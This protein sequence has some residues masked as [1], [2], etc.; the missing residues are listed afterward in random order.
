M[1]FDFDNTLDHRYN[2]S[3][4]WEQQ[5]YRDDI[6]G[7]GTADLD[8]ACAPCIKVAL[9]K[10]ASEN[11]YNYRK[12]SDDYFDTVINWYFRKYEL[13]IQKEWLS[14]VPSTIGSIR[15][16]LALWGNGKKV[17][18]Q[19]PYFGPLRN[20]IES[21]G[22][23][24]IDNPMVINDGHF[25]I[26]FED[27]ERKIVKEKPAVFL[28]VNPH[29]P[30]G[31]VFTREELSRLVEICFAH[32]VLILSDEVHS[33][34]CY[35]DNKHI[36]ILK[37]SEKAKHISVQVMSM[38][39]GFNM[40]SLPHAI[41][42]IA[43]ASLREEWL[44]EIIP[45]SFGYA[46][47]SF[48]IAAV[49]AVMKEGD[50]WLSAVTAYLDENRKKVLEFLAEFYPDVKVYSPEGGYLIWIDIKSQNIGEKPAVFFVEKFGISLNDGAEFGQE[51]K[52]YIRINFGLPKAKLL[53]AL[54]RIKS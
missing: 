21:A 50:E 36:P 45:Y 53:E 5:K 1:V 38:S 54:N 43:D 12:K 13:E 7:M 28:L 19:S 23:E 9:E 29:N 16:A 2:D 20:A 47:N 14:N 25:E 46:T 18:M 15:I 44:K 22:C 30:T 3:Y 10:V 51:G 42:S 26:D 52:G 4:K 35:G 41:I 39:K 24:F 6:I 34:I 8:F 27:F 49:M 31:R 11:T 48:S 17:I 33:L 40:M 37:V 32:N